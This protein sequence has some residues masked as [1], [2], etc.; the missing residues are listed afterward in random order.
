MKQR[1][2]VTA[3]V[4]SLLTC[5]IYSIIWYVGLIDDLATLAEDHSISGGKALIFSI[6]TCGIY[7]V[8]SYYKIGD[9]E[10]TAMQKHLGVT[11]DNAVLYL[12]LCLF[13]LAI[14]PMCIAQSNVNKIIGSKQVAM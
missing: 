11:K 12:I 9:L 6:L 7:G 14:I 10:S 8:Y 2:P 13:G 5:G 1:N 3:I 4:L